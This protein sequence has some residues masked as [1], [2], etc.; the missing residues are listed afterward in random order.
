MVLL[1]IL[2][3][4]FHTKYVIDMDK[5]KEELIDFIDKSTSCYT[6]I[7]E[8]KKKLDSYG[9]IELYEEEWN[10]DDNKYYVVRNDASIIAFELPKEKSNSFHIITS[11]CDTPSL[12]LKPSG[13]YIS[14]NYLKY[15]VMPYGGLL[16]YGWLDHS[17]SLSGRVI[18]KEGN[19]LVSKIVDIKK[20]MLIVPSVAIH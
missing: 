19:I 7:E 6:C 8:I 11:C 5:F 2:I 10:L 14:D 17:L 15:N 1:Y 18:V 3:I 16:N 13:A 4:A 20:P 12:I 9:Y